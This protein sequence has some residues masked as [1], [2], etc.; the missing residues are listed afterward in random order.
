MKNQNLGGADYL[1]EEPATIQRDMG[2]A[3]TQFRLIKARSKALLAGVHSAV[4]P[5]RAYSLRPN[6][7][8]AS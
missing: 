2:L 8:L 6:A 4:G 7:A 1:N 5:Q 3:E